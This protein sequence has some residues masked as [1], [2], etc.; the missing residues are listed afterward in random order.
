MTNT[1]IMFINVSHNSSFEAEKM[2]V[3]VFDKGEFKKIAKIAE[4]CR[5]KKLD[6]EGIAKVKARTRKYLYTIKIK[7]DELDAFLKELECKN[8]V[9]V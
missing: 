6:K 7:I 4:E 9:E 5:V 1:N 3:E 8:I 2:P